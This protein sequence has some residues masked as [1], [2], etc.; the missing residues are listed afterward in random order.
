M[1]AKANVA[2]RRGEKIFN[3]RIANR[4]RRIPKPKIKTSKRF[5]SGEQKQK[6]KHSSE[7]AHGLIMSLSPYRVNAPTALE[8]LDE[9]ADCHRR[10]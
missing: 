9:P 2:A 6:Q 3:V 5:R 1:V 4:E 10:A 8:G 7:Y